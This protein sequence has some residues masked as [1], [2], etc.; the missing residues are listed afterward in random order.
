MVNC[1]QQKNGWECG[2]MV[3]K[4]MY[5]FVN[6]IQHDFPNKVSVL[7]TLCVALNYI[8]FKLHVFY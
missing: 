4:N 2:F 7:H 8:F 5:E 6:T 1:K 3:I